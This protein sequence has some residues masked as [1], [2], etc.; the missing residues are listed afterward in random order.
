VAWFAA[1]V[2]SDKTMFEIYRESDY[3]RAFRCIF[4]TDLEE[5]ARGPEIARAA[6]GETV[7]SGFFADDKKAAARE[8]VDEIVDEL[9]AMNDE[10]SDTAGMPKQA[11]AS[12]LGKFMVG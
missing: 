2:S 6:A 8:V 9:N 1:M 11:F 3:N 7:F 10:D 12:R 5:H 4:Y